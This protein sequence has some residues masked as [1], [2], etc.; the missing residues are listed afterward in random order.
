MRVIP[1]VG[2]F[3]KKKPTLSVFHVKI[4]VGDILC[5][6]FLDAAYVAFFATPLRACPEAALLDSVNHARLHLSSLGIPSIKSLYGIT[7]I[8]FLYLFY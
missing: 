8:L 4:P 6:V 3:Q 2:N 7:W 1:T 5:I